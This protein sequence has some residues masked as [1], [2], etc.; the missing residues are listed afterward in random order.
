MGGAG[1]EPALPAWRACSPS[2]HSSLVGPPGI[3]PSSAGLQPAAV[4]PD[5][6]ETHDPENDVV[7]R[8]RIEFFY[9]CFNPHCAP[10]G[11]HRSRR[12]QPAETA[13]RKAVF[14]AAPDRTSP[15]EPPRRA[16]RKLRWGCCVVPND[17]R[18]RYGEGE[19]NPGLPEF[20][21]L[22]CALRFSVWMPP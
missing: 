11:T 4:S 14:Q 16:R 7:S 3:E 22:R 21:R 10:V 6:L 18:R 8:A 19:S 2:V 17:I 1:V 15:P 9:S 5:L 12:Q 20:W 13:P